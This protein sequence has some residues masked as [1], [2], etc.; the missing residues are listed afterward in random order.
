MHQWRQYFCGRTPKKQGRFLSTRGHIG[1]ARL[2]CY[3]CC[4]HCKTLGV[5]WSIICKFIQQNRIIDAV[6]YQR[7][8]FIAPCVWADSSLFVWREASA[9]SSAVCCCTTAAVWRDPR[10]YRWTSVPCGRQP[11]PTRR[12]TSQTFEFKTHKL[13]WLY[14]LKLATLRSGLVCCISR[15]R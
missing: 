6:K 12:S 13:V 9:G 15:F 4:C 1:L 10:R 5:A 8:L 3:C 14:N 7:L 11:H 2:C